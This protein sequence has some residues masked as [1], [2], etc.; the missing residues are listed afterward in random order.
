[1]DRVALEQ[2]DGEALIAIILSQQELIERLMAEV[3]DLKAQIGRP[4]K[5]SGNSTVPPSVGFK[6]TRAERRARKRR[7]AHV[8]LLAATLSAQPDLRC[9][10]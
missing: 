4:P 9:P 2:A 7:R 1:M 10:I 8:M 5:T 6:A 3:A